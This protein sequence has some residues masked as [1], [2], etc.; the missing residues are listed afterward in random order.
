MTIPQFSLMVKNQTTDDLAVFVD[1]CSQLT[2][3]TGSVCSVIDRQ[4]FLLKVINAITT[5]DIF[6]SFSLSRSLSL[7]LSLICSQ[8][9]G[10]G[11]GS[12]EAK[13]PQTQRF[14]QFANKLLQ[15]CIH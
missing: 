13:P 8:K 14:Y 2:S 7:L 4:S 10:K 12:K 15:R 5:D 3:D 1:H 11:F 9:R 6:F